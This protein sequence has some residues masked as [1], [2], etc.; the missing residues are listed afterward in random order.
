MKC[1]S[2][3]AILKDGAKLCKSCGTKSMKPHGPGIPK[4]VSRIVL[5]PSPLGLSPVDIEIL[6]VRGVGQDGNGETRIQI[7]YEVKNNTDEDWIYLD[8]SIQLLSSDGLI[9]DEI[10]DREEQV[11][12]AG[13]SHKFESSS[14]W[15]QHK[16]L[17]AD[18]RK[19]RVIVNVLACGGVQQ[20]LGEIDIPRKPFEMAA[21]KPV[22]IGGVVQL[23]TGS[24][25]RTG[26]NLNKIA[27]VE[28]R[29]LV[30]SLTVKHLPHLLAAVAVAVD[31]RNKAGRSLF[32]SNWSREVRVGALRTISGDGIC[33]NSELKDCK[34]RILVRVSWPVA[35]GVCQRTGMKIVASEDDGDESDSIDSEGGL[36][37]GPPGVLRRA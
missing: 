13:K 12:N 30:Q 21:L 34:A 27:T 32:I 37:F 6:E 36:V 5:P 8:V 7:K 14:W 17:G 1:L 35:E 18:A 22:K 16:T 11:I 31:I 9:I 2:C 33:K 24:L 4:A 10:K 3:G 19:A 23:V 26:P 25:W 15:V 29:A 20:R 28:V